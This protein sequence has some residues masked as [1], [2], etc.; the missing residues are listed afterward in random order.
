M[1]GNKVAELRQKS[2]GFRSPSKFLFFQA[3]PDQG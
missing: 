2:Q 3:V 1:S